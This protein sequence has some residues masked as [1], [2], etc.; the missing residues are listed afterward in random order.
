MRA[1]C[2][3]Q[4]YQ[5]DDLAHQ[6]RLLKLGDLAREFAALTFKLLGSKPHMTASRQLL[7]PLGMGYPP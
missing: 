2:L 4:T 7:P 3:F 5:F 1:L 6:R